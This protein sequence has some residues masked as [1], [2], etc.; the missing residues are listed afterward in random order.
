MGLALEP[1]LGF[2]SSALRAS[3]PA[4]PPPGAES[5]TGRFPQAPKSPYFPPPL[6]PR[7]P[8]PPGAALLGEGCVCV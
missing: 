5:P 7:I 6:P 1:G 2:P 3:L 4:A 8:N